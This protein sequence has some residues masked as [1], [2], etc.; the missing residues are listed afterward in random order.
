MASLKEGMER[1]ICSFLRIYLPVHGI[2][3]RSIRVYNSQLLIFHGERGQK[4][5]KSVDAEKCQNPQYTK[6]YPLSQT[7]SMAIYPSQFQRGKRRKGLKKTRL[8]H[9][10][11][12]V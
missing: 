9:P 3:Q 2:M 7:Q 1:G 5:L 11:V 4:I 6:A 12:S 8:T 10:G